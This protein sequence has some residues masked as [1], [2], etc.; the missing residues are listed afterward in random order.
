[1]N[2]LLTAI[3]A[4]YIHSNLAVYSLRAYVP[5]K[6]R[7][8]VEIAEYTINHRSEFIL[9][10]LYK[11]APDVLCFSCYIWN[12]DFVREIAAEYHKLRPE[13]PIWAGGPEVSFEI[14]QVFDE[15]PAFFGIMA[16][17]GEAT[18]GK[19]AEYYCGEREGGLLEIPGIAFRSRES[20]KICGTL[21]GEPLDFSS[22]PFCYGDMQGF[23]NRIIYYESSRGCPFSCS[24]CLSSVDKRLRFREI[25]RV[26]DELLFFIEKEVPQVKF[27]DRTFNCNHAHAMEI[28]RFIKEQDK[29]ITNFHFEIAA[30]LLSAEELVFLA[31]LRP[32]L[33]QFEIGVQ[34]T[35]HKTLEAIRRTTDL[36]KVHAAVRKIQEVGNIHIHLDLIAGLP[37]EGYARFRQSFNEVY[38][39]KPD[40]LQLGFLKVLKGSDLYGHR[41]EYGLIYRTHPPYEVL[42]TNWLSYDE[43]LLIKLVEEMLETYYNSGQFEVTMK[44]LD[45]V[46]QDAFGFFLELGRF[47]ERNGELYRKHSR[48][49]RCELLLEFAKE[50]GRIPAGL[51]EES[52]LYDLYYRENMK[53]RPGWARNPAEFAKVTKAVCKSGKLSHVEP[54]FY[55][56]PKKEERTLRD[57]PGRLEEAV[58]VLFEYE[59]RDV[60]SRQAK[61]TELP[62]EQYVLPQDADSPIQERRRN[63]E[64]THKR[65]YKTFG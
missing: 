50:D 21:P 33:V 16:G 65:N 25:S 58:Y 51:L 41:E 19:L 56:F 55:H 61:T 48:I 36:A 37:Y 8:S 12:Y 57:L 52:L 42:Q 27:V 32:G 17:E 28:W 9:Q 29:G 38:A 7:E 23:E 40:Q 62:Q 30:D 39:W 20:G 2:I 15:N 59:K 13:V 10:E 26:K 44:L 18:F 31:G 47:Y 14:A 46:Y 22:I 11:K 60:L 24:Y 54:F 3:N 45:V 4:K 35:N 1:M 5:E 64:K 53:S 34:S 63:R 43:V 6:C 49:R